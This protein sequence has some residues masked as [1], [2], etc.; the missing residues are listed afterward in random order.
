MKT[1]V[2]HSY[3]GGV[4]RTLTVANFVYALA[5]LGKRVVAIDFDLEAPGLAY[6]FNLENQVLQ[7]YVDY[8]QTR[9][10]E[11]DKR[12]STDDEKLQLIKKIA[13]AI[14]GTHGSYLLPAGDPQSSYYWEILASERF[15]RLFYFYGNDNEYNQGAFI[16][17]ARLIKQALA[18]DYLLVDCKNAT[19]IAA[20][21][22]MLWADVVVNMVTN[23]REGFQ[24]AA[25]VQRA[26]YRHWKT[27]AEQHDR[28]RLVSV[29]CRLPDGVLA[30]R[31][32]THFVEK[33]KAVWCGLDAKADAD[34]KIAFPDCFR[35]E[36]LHEQRGLE[37]EETILL[38]QKETANKNLRL[39][40]DY[41]TLFERIVPELTNEL[42][43]TDQAWKELLGMADGVDLVERYFNL[44]LHRG[45]LENVD[46][47]PNVS[48]RVTTF[49]SLLDTLF[50]TSIQ[51]S[52][53]PPEE[54]R[55]LLERAIYQSGLT[56]GSNFAAEFLTNPAV[57]SGGV[58]DDLPTRCHRWCDFDSSVGFGKFVCQLAMDGRSGQITLTGNILTGNR[59]ADAPNL[60]EFFR[61]YVHGVLAQL[62]GCALNQLSVMA[63]DNETFEFKFKI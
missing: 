29:L 26:I 13:L 9:I 5:A 11:E 43:K 12:T 34:K 18:P 21:P 4:G 62:A 58:P 40:H 45:C 17:D 31:A 49:R 63:T 48:F 42:V 56:T 10:N 44:Y 55:C 19:E 3:K 6:K 39:S 16:E 51:E 24:G 35:F 52:T 30:E 1:I 54:T 32:S 8:L 2:F 61:G 47:Q 41:I 20:V 53:L 37:A 60:N 7:G 33:F 25:L 14:P 57:W 22:L 50:A 23:N 27:N 36:V 28:K 59:S 15:H 46:H 38:A